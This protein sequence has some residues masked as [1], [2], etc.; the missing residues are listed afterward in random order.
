MCQT[1]GSSLLLKDRY[2]ALSCIGQGGFG[3]TFLAID[4]DKPS[5]PQCVIKQFLP[6]A[7]GTNNVQKAAQLFEQE[8]VRLE[9]LG[10]HQQIPALH[11]HFTQDRRQYLVQEFIDGKNLGQ[12]LDRVGVFREKEI[13][14]FL[15]N[16][17]PVLDFIHRHKVIHRDI[18]P[19]NII[20][21]QNGE[22]VLVD[23]GA[24]KYATSTALL[25]T[26]TTI[27]TPEY[28]APEQARGRAVFSS[29]L[30]SLGVTCLHLLTDKSPF[31][32]FDIHEDT[33]IWREALGR[34]R[35]SDGLAEIID[36][37]IAD[38]IKYRYRSARE[39]LQDLQQRKVAKPDVSRTNLPQ[40]HREQSDRRPVVSRSTVPPRQPPRK[41]AP[42]P[43]P[44]VSTLSQ[45]WHCAH[46]L[47]GH[48]AWV[49]AIAIHPNSSLIASGSEDC[50]IRFWQS[51]TGEQQ[52][53]LRGLP[54]EV[55]ALA[56]SP[57]GQFLASGGEKGIVYLWD[58]HRGECVQQLSGH[59]DAI[60]AIAWNNNGT[61]LASGSK[62]RTAKLW[63][64]DAEGR[65]YGQTLSTLSGHS[66]SVRCIGFSPDSQTVA[67]GSDDNYIKLWHVGRE[68]EFA[69][70]GDLVSR[71]KIVT[72]VAFHPD[73]KRLASG[74]WD[75]LVKLWDVQTGN[76]MQQFP[77]HEDY[78]RSIAFSPDGGYLV[79]GS[80]DRTVKLWSL[81]R[82]D[83]I[84]TLAG[85]AN[86]VNQVAWSPDG[87]F[88]VSAS[89]DTTV[90]IWQLENARSSRKERESVRAS[91]ATIS[92]RSSSSFTSRRQ[93]HQP[94]L[95]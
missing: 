1:C 5:Q 60:N 81:E 48:R 7:Q 90:K 30:Y 23:F 55:N 80:D 53:T 21:R 89:A 45:P 43:S 69:T 4:L 57:D 49:G 9:D 31:E 72:S 40:R 93:V 91:S 51:N 22:L 29:D 76:A 26:G 83:C 46:T 8:A 62:D 82:E 44:S 74:G 94:W 18:K 86:A 65:D 63:Q 20:L 11:A 35:V 16:L 37:L 32:L 52:G 10:Q 15:N 54:G 64:L 66:A 85:H 47:Q 2:Q 58:L 39:V 87:R 17:L 3:R 12:V 27:G 79:S 59:E 38:A 71:L 73:G 77:G 6:Q 92:A 33:W 67:T 14:D 41:P 95:D 50:T 61:L 78:V 70:L 13:R 28:L 19:D 56:F 25:K 42:V 34:N 84:V 68:F 88:L 24:A 75:N 36:K